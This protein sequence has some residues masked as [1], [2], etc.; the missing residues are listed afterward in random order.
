MSH[1]IKPKKR[2]DRLASR[3]KDWESSNSKYPSCYT[4]PGSKRR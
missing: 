2:A 3:I 4:K 1:Y